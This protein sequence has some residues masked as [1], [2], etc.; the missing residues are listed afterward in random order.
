M[1]SV[2]K[3]EGLGKSYFISHRQGEGYATLRERLGRRCSRDRAA[4]STEMFWALHDVNFEIAQGE[5]VGVVGRNGAGK[6]TLLKILS[7]ITPPTLGRV[8]LNGRVASLLEVGTGFHPELTGRENIFLNGAI[9]GMRRREIRTRFDQIVEFAEI[10]RFLD[11][12]VKRYSSGM[13]TRLAFAVAA[14]LDSDILLLDEVLAVGDALFQKK[15]L[16]R[17]DDLKSAGRTVLLVSHNMAS[18]QSVCERAILLEQGG[19]VMDA[20]VDQTVERYL[21]GISEAG[22]GDLSV[23]HAPRG[24]EL[25]HQLRIVEC[26]LLDG[27]GEV[28]DKLRF[29]EPFAIRMKIRGSRHLVQTTLLVGIDS[30][31]STERITTLSA[32]YDQL[33][34]DP[35]GNEVEVTVRVEDFRLRPGLYSIVLGVRRGRVGLDQ[36]PMAR[37]FEVLPLT[38]S[39]AGL[40]AAIWGMVDVEG[41][42]RLDD[43]AGRR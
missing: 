7:R 36:V 12:P 31:R 10:E 23:A 6:S 38:A 40:P 5:K 15:C 33:A 14:H 19:V 11:T 28:V 22:G 29:G 34:G 26:A 30:V 35:S 3:V 20:T 37:V 18:I 24:E 16:S 42:W 25:G 9:L 32:D 43:V 21:K 13:Y 17:I 2:I 4:T 41:T 1:S 39:G 27:S 8:T